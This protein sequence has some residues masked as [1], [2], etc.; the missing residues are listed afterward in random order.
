MEH[1]AT[2]RAIWLC[3]LVFFV[4]PVGLG[5]WLSRVAEVQSVLGLSKSDLALALVGMPVG[6]LP[7]LYVAGRVVDR[8]GPRRALLW[9]FPPMLAIG[10]LPG[11]AG[12]LAT[13]FLA[14][15]LFGTV[16]A[17][18][19]VALNVYAARVEKACDK[20]IMNRAHGF[21]SLG[22]MAGS[23]IG[24]QLVGLEMNAAQSLTV[25]GLVLLPIT[26]AVAFAL[27]EV[28]L[29]ASEG[30]VQTKTPPIP[31]A[32]YVIMLIVL[33]ATLAEGAMIDWATVYMREVAHYVPGREGLA[34][35][36]FS[37][38]VTVGR[39]AGDAINTRFGATI[40]ARMCLGSALVGLMILIF[41]L[42]PYPSFLGFALVGL[43]VSTI[44]PLGVSASAAL[45]KTGEARNVSVMTFGALSGFLVGP[46]AIG[47]AAQATSLDLAFVLLFPGLLLSF[48]LARRLSTQ[49]VS[50]RR[51]GA[52]S[53]P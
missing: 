46:P 40:L 7:T 53:S 17:F 26:M 1:L 39:F 43:G 6:L 3:M 32:L 15:F 9:A 35:T 18:T 2:R 27:P 44:F 51:A 5:I 37:G 45:S 36:V 29:V 4:Q 10:I 25:G 50:E 12:G 31:K 42:G 30:E 14:L 48:L 41:N 28:N 11:L 33:G 22:V 13:L 24:V 52:P 19:E 21:W 34:V 8:V 16:V 47:F 23:F 49:S 20:S 38:F